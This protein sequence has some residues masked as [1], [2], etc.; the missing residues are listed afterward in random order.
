MEE[1]KLGVTMEINKRE[2]R[3]KKGKENKRN[4]IRLDNNYM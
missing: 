3:R 2:E 4:K 1:W